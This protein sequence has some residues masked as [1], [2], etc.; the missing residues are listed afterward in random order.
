MC[1]GNYEDLRSMLSLRRSIVSWHFRSFRG[2]RDRMRAWADD[3]EGPRVV[4]LRSPAATRRWLHR[5]AA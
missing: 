2:K 1:N 4:L 3:P 5:L